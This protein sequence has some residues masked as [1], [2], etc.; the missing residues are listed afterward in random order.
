MF[1]ILVLMLNV[2][3]MPMRAGRAIVIELLEKSLA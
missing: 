3:V 2:I 1:Y